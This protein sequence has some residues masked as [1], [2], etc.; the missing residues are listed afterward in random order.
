MMRARRSENTGSSKTIKPAGLVRTITVRA[1]SSPFESDALTTST[2]TPRVRPVSLITASRG[3]VIGL[4]GFTSTVARVTCHVAARARE[5]RY[6]TRAHRIVECVEYDWNGTRGLFRRLSSR[7]RSRKN[8]I[9][10]EADEVGGEWR[11]TLVLLPSETV[12]DHQILPLNPA[13]LT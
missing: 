5:A 11:Q 12:L 1:P 13:V 6:E 2:S 7:R 10:L 3:G 4:A 8:N 9:Y